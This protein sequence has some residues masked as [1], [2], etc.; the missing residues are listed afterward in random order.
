[1]SLV[2]TSIL[3]HPLWFRIPESIPLLGIG[4]TVYDPEF[5]LEA[6]CFEWQSALGLRALERLPSQVLRRSEHARRLLLSLE[7]CPGWTAPAP[8]RADGPIRLPLLAPDRGER[9]RVVIA[10]RK[11]GVRA[12][13]MYPGTIADI[14]ALRPH[15]ANPDAAIPGARAIA[16]RLLTL[17]IYPTL[18][19]ADLERVGSAFRAALRGRAQ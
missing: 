19:A 11:L 1:V 17:P 6:P 10:L 13:C 2:A 9:E 16:E 3:S 7:E 5:A 14:D 12:S 8:A 15:L 4:E 18:A